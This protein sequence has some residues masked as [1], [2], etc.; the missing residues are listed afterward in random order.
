M[1]CYLHLRWY[2]YHNY[3]CYYHS[4]DCNHLHRY[5]LRLC[6]HSFIKIWEMSG[7]AKLKHW[8]C[9]NIPNAEL[10]SS[11]QK[12]NLWFCPKPELFGSNLRIVDRHHQDSWPTTLGTIGWTLTCHC[13][14]KSC[15]EVFQV[16]NWDLKR[17]RSRNDKNLSS[18]IISLLSWWQEVHL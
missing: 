10:M 13:N 5:P 15:L 4:K 8:S 7:W 11:S 14:A 9:G 16:G 1:R 2:F 6:N 3:P 12:L 17:L 18:P